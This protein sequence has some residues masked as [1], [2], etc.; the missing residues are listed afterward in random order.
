METIGYRLT[1]GDQ[2]DPHSLGI[3][4]EWKLERYKQVS[5]LLEN[6]DPHSLGIL[7]EWKRETET[8]KEAE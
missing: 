3:L 5:L 4:I 8:H 7:I 6:G 2:P 1:Q